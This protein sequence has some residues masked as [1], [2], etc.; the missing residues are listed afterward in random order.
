MFLLQLNASET[1]QL[2]LLHWPMQMYKHAT[3]NEYKI[4]IC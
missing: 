3:E 2:W 1:V 4:V